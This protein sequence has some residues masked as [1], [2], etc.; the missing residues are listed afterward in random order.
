M[1]QTILCKVKVR[2]PKAEDN[3]EKSYNLEVVRRFLE[4]IEHNQVPTSRHIESGTNAGRPYR[5]QEQTEE[6]TG[7]LSPRKSHA[8]VINEICQDDRKDNPAN[9][10]ASGCIGH[11]HGTSLREVVTDDREGRGKDETTGDAEEDA[12]AEEE[13]V[14]LSTKASEHHGDHKQNREGPNDNLRSMVHQLQFQVAFRAGKR[15]LESF[16]P[17]MVHT[18]GP[19][20]SVIGPPSKLAE[21]CAKA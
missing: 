18:I 4:G 21:N 7:T 1:C 9:G 2:S 3:H 11:S 5:E 6:A 20:R 15:N 10:R 13:L 16:A 12:L 14:E 19:H 17:W 8:W